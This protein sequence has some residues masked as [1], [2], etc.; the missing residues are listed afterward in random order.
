MK[1]KIIL[2]QLKVNLKLSKFIRIL[3]CIDEKRTELSKTLGA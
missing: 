1:T 2:A 3:Y